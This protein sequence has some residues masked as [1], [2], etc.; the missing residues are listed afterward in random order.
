[1]NRTGL[2]FIA[3]V[4][5][6][7]LILSTSLY[8]VD[9]REM[10]VVTAFGKPVRTVSEPGLQVR[11]PY[12][13]HEVVRF[14]HRT[15]LLEAEPAELLTRDKKNLVIESFVLWRIADPQLFLEAV[16]RA[17]LAEVQLSDLVVSRLAANLGQR[18][19]GDLVAVDNETTDMLPPELTRSVAE[20]AAK[21]LGVEVMQVRVRHVGFPLQNQQSIYERMRAERLRIANAYRSEGQEK[22]AVIR[23]EADRQA[24]E[25][26]A[27]AERDAAILRAF[28]DRLT[29]RMFGAALQGRG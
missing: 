28:D 18:D 11:L 16:G 17:E 20:I 22:A 23:A 8:T 7:L 13:I 26:M 29:E 4:S 1:M 3:F 27:I 2:L 12:P 14:D 19:F 25:L 10:V 21:R 15:R 5:F 24:A 6:S 9:A